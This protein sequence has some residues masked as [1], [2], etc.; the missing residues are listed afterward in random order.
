[1]PLPVMTAEELCRDTEQRLQS[2]MR[3]LGITGSI[4]H[5]ARPDKQYGS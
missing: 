3:V 4:T 2:S 5:I 1:M